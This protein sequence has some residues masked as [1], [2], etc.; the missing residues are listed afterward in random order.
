LTAGTTA[1]TFLDTR[2]YDAL[3]RLVLEVDNAGHATDLRYDG[4]MKYR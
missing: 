2:F 4:P 1:A 3:D